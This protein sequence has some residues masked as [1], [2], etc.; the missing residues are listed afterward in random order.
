[1][2]IDRPNIFLI[3]FDTM[4]KDALSVYEGQSSTPNLDRFSQ[5]CTVCPNAISTAPWTV[6]SHASFF[7][8]KYPSGHGVH[9]TSQV[10]LADM[11][12]IF[13]ESR[14]KAL[15]EELHKK[16]Y[17]TIGYSANDVAVNP[18]L[19]FDRGFDLFSNST[20]IGAAERRFFLGEATRMLESLE[21]NRRQIFIKLLKKGE[22]NLISR[23]I[24]Q[25]WI[26]QRNERK[27]G[28][29]FLKGANAIISNVL[30]STMEEPFFLF[31][32]LMEM[33][34]PYFRNSGDLKIGHLD[35]LGIHSISPSK[36]IRLRKLYYKEASVIDK[37]F[38]LLMDFIKR[39]GWYDSSLIIVTSDHGQSLKENH[40]YGHGIY[41]KDEI[42]QVPL[43]IKLPKNKKI[44]PDGYQSTSVI[45][46][47]I[48]GHA[49]G[50]FD[51]DCIS[52]ETVF[53]ESYGSHTNWS[54]ELQKK[55]EELSGLIRSKD[56]FDVRKAVFK[57]GFKLT[58]NGVRGIVEEFKHN[59]IE[60]EIEAHK[61]SYQDLLE[62]LEIFKGKEKF[63]LP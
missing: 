6:P 58:V 5:D 47:V 22:W 32:N 59:G 25:D 33:H 49:D 26:T 17:T 4:R 56:I 2:A 54:L 43:L 9:E 36:V 61:S 63:N 28:F 62:E 13:L 41:L 34:E 42:I 55:P 21:G 20:S 27:E 18:Y 30:R 53:A 19:G 1:M 15:P 35:T 16:G 50:E 52:R 23:L 48:N 11:K 29:P 37:Y 14:G 24:V 44:Q 39:M 3:I 46:D 7:T 57:K 51:P 60:T 40:F 10:K 45:Y 12:D 38:G 8:G 31:I